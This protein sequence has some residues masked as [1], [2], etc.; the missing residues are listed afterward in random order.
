MPPRRPGTCATCNAHRCP[1][2]HRSHRLSAQ[3][4]AWY[5]SSVM[6]ESESPRQIMKRVYKQRGAVLTNEEAQY[7]SAAEPRG[8]K[9]KQRPE[10]SQ[11][12]TTVRSNNGAQRINRVR[13]LQHHI[14][15][16]EDSARNH[17]RRNHHVTRVKRRQRGV[18]RAA[19]QA[20]RVQCATHARRETLFRNVMV[21][22]V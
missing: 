7:D 9:V 3:R 6:R 1:S 19:R 22:A 2:T 8:N 20:Y 11:R 18:P 10:G 13:F 14:K 4:R 21:A 5:S 17:L 16:G 15:N 12:V